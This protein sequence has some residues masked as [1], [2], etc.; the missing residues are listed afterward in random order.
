MKDVSKDFFIRMFMWDGDV[1]SASVKQD[2]TIIL[3]QI[4]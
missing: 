2:K 3:C 1:P 4:L